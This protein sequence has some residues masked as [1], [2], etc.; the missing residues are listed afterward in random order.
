MHFS[1]QRVLLIYLFCIF[2]VF[3]PAM[4]FCGVNLPARTITL[5][6]AYRQARAN[7]PLIKQR[8]L[9]SRTKEYTVAN[10][11]KGYLPAV[12]FNGQGTYQSAVTSFPFTL[13]IP[14]FSMPNYS[15][16]Q[17]KAYGE[18]DQ[19]IYDGGAIKNQQRMA[20][21]NEAVQQQSLEVQLYELFD[22][23]NQLYF[24]ALLIE[25]QIKLNDLLQKDIE[26]G[27]E[28]AKG[29]Y[30]NGTAYR[31][32][33]DEF[34]AQLMQAKQSRVELDANHK[35]FLTMLSTFLSDSSGA[36]LVLT[37]PTLPTMVDGINRPEL[38]YYD[39]QKKVFDVQENMLHVQLRPKL[40]F[41]FQGGYGR[42]GL[43]ML[44][45]DFAW[46]YIGG[47]RLNWNLG[48][49]YDLHDQKEI[50]NLGRANL[51]VQKE[52]FLFNTELN[53]RQQNS[54]IEK[55]NTLIKDDNEIID[56]RTSVKK[57]AFAQ[58]ENGVLS[59]HDYMTQVDAEDQ[60]RQN[61]AL[62]NVQREQAEYTYQVNLG[63]IKIQ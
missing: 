13:P 10:A 38:P 25:E 8:G 23:I 5:D 24:G 60:A 33:L 22:R 3:L 6:D 37:H 14:G 4:L 42:P 46:Y 52:T 21:A 35:A 9:I 53:R 2:Q 41:F 28:K 58:L 36:D 15:K 12:V 47:L 48:S 43:N 56:L 50:I 20:K 17:Y 39:Y 27:L 19:N 63:N 44:S 26:N 49:L 29:Q 32:S 7:F 59:A 55:Y 45:N 40:S 62:H 61:Q 11:A 31:S 30:A 54:D 18:V 57:A 16:D 1:T 34:Q 51:D